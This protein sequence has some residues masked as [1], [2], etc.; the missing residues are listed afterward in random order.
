MINLA[1]T[2]QAECGDM[3]DVKLISPGFV[4]TPLTDK[5]TFAMPMMIE[6]EQAADA[7]A[8]GL[9]SRAFEIHFPQKNLP[10]CSSFCAC[11][12]THWPCD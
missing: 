1:E 11:C 8:D 7:I 4:R 3:I 10:C 5:N 2:L 6:P 9:Q 12:P